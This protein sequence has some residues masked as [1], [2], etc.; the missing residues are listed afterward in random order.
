MKTFAL[1]FTEKP[2]LC[3]EGYLMVVLGY[4]PKVQNTLA[5]GFGMRGC[6][7]ECMKHVAQCWQVESSRSRDF[8]HHCRGSGNPTGVPGMCQ[9]H[10]GGMQGT[11]GGREMFNISGVPVSGLGEQRV[12]FRARLCSQGAL[13]S[14]SRSAI[15]KLCHLG[16]VTNLSE[17]PFS[18]L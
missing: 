5:P 14:D 13:S 17:S 10:K 2:R 3:W 11:R 6:G 12:G 8:S 16:Q 1:D 9:T 4:L 15:S 7:P 18:H